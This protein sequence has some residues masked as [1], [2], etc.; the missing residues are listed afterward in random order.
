MTNS[1]SYLD[2]AELI[3]RESNRPLK[4]KEII[5]AIQNKRLIKISGA[6]P[7]KTM[8]ARLSV[9]IK[10]KGEESR[11]KRVGRGLYTLRS[12][13]GEEYPAIPHQ[14]HFLSHNRWRRIRW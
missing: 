10:K 13:N 7:L 11:F 8:N 1:L 9:D 2:V 4:A 6:T 5:L 12:N 14:R 3:L